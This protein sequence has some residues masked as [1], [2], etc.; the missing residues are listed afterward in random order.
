MTPQDIIRLWFVENGREEWFKKDE[1]FDERIRSKFLGTHQDVRTG[2]TAAWRNTPEGR[3]AE[4]LVLDQF[5]RNMF[6]GTPEAFAGDARAL[7]LAKEA[8]A[9]GD[10]MRVDAS[11]RQFFYMPYMHSES[12]E[13]HAEAVPL[14][15]K[16]GDPEVLKYELMHK[17]IIDRFGRYPHRNRILGRTSTPE[18][19][20]FLKEHEGF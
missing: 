19:E 4:I 11:K 13:V 14:F 1:A 20:A 3:L 9:A 10:D 16:L 17:D 6:R 5:A 12:S 8:V 7:A 15:E 18:E 2:A